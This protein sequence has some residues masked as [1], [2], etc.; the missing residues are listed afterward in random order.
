MIVQVRETEM[1]SVCMPAFSTNREEVL[2]EIKK[3]QKVELHLHL[4]GAWPLE[5]F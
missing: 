1:K 4:G 2:R 3:L 5:F